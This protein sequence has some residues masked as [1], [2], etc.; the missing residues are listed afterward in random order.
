MAQ[1]VIAM[2]SVIVA[3]SRSVNP[4]FQIQ[5]YITGVD[6]LGVVTTNWAIP[7]SC[8][9]NHDAVY[10][11]KNANPLLLATDPGGHAESA[12]DGALL[13]MDMSAQA[14]VQTGCTSGIPGTH[15][16]IT[17]V[18]AG[19]SVYLLTLHEMGHMFGAY[20]DEDTTPA[21]RIY[22]SENRNP[23]GD[24]TAS[25]SHKN[26]YL[27]SYPKIDFSGSNKVCEAWVAYYSP[28]T[29]RDTQYWISNLPKRVIITEDP[30]IDS[31]KIAMD[32]FRIVFP[33]QVIPNHFL[34]MSRTAELGSK[35]ATVTLTDMFIRGN[36]CASRAMQCCPKGATGC[37]SLNFDH[38][39][40]Y[41]L[42]DKVRKTDQM[43]MSIPNGVNGVSVTFWPDYCYAATPCVGRDYGRDAISLDVV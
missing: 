17:T 16:W 14:S 27:M 40:S 21:V 25:H 24:C 11:F 37:T 2:N 7:G 9:L 20:H 3:Q 6:L 42:Q 23:H 18:P 13:F 19:T 12:E 36:Q 28:T 43:A 29:F 32:E 38:R 41:T 15:A 30:Q 10:D 8:K 5:L 39:A 1:A 35:G 33:T 34:L 4:L 26:M 31:K 22:T